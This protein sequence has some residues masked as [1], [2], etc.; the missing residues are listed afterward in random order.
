[1]RLA[2]AVLAD[3]ANVREDLMNVLSAGITTVGTA[4]LP[5]KASLALCLMLEV[6]GEELAN[7]GAREVHI[8]IVDRDADE[9]F[10]E[11]EGR[12][13]WSA[14]SAGSQ[15]IPMPLDLS[16]VTFE[17]AG[18]HFVAV[19]IDDLGLVTIPFTVAAPPVDDASP[20]SEDL[21]HASP[22]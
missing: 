7:D 19:H 12:V 18:A 15:Y 11:I 14:S 2:M 9:V 13:S 4:E 1:M 3:A 16:G 17:K 21:P 10:V 8:A 22:A 5:G 20:A 6:T